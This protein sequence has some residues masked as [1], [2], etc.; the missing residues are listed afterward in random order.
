MIDRTAPIVA[1]G[2]ASLQSI[3]PPRETLNNLP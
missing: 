2:I 1:I 3:M